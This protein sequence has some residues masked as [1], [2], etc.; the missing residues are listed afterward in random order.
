[1][2]AWSVRDIRAE[3]LQAADWS[4]RLARRGRWRVVVVV[5]RAVPA[6]ML[7]ALLWVNDDDVHG[8]EFLKLWWNWAPLVAD[9]IALRRHQL[10]INAG[11]KQKQPIN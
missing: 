7:D 6:F 1:M 2:F 10:S 3:L 8:T 5:R 11:T 4:D 9:L